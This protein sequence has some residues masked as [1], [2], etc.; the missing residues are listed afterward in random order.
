MNPWILNLGQPQG[1]LLFS[2]ESP[3]ACHMQGQATPCR[4][5]LDYPSFILWVLRHTGPLST[6][7]SKE[8]VFAEPHTAN[9]GAHLSPFPEQLDAFTFT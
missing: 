3:L 2:K 9:Q 6:L 1:F 7:E 5:T 4:V 8:R